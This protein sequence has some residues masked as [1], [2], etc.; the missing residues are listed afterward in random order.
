MKTDKPSICYEAHGNLYLNITNQCSADCYF[1]IRNQGEGLYGHNLW[2]KKD[3]SKN[4]MI[5]ELEKHDLKKYKEI[6]FTGFGEPTTRFD[7][8]LA[9]TRWL[10]AKGAY[11]R[12]DTNGHGQLINPETNVVDC[13]VDAGLDAV[14][15][16]LN[17]ES[18]EVYD[19]ICKPFYQNAYGALLE[20][21]EKS[22]EA[23]L[24]VRFSVVNVPEI[25][26]EK[27]NQIARDMGVDF[28][29]RG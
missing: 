1:C 29:I 2:L 5:A 15:V 11:V 9:V 19:R 27:C 12:L 24:Y 4:E 26:T 7:M 14:S 16:S 17:A 10:K 8:L 20:F 3:P 13:L 22:K 18:T 23:G 6:V 25:D 28:R 21:A